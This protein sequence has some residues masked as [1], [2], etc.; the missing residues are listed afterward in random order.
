M[1]T[2]NVAVLST[3]APLI[4]ADAER[5]TRLS[6]GGVIGGLL[7]AAAVWIGLTVLGLAVNLS[8]IE[9]SD[10]AA[11]LKG[12]G[13]AAGIWSLVVWVVALFAGA[14]VASHTAGIIE[15]PHGALHGIVLWSL[16]TVLGIVV[17][18]GTLGT[19]VRGAVATAEST[20]A[21]ANA[22]SSGPG[23]LLGLDVD[24]LIQPLN[25][26]LRSEGKPAVTASQV[27]GA[28]RDV[29]VNA[30]QQGH[31]DRDV[32]IRAL[33]EKASLAHADAEDL[34]NQIDTWFD[35]HAEIARDVRGAVLSAA[36]STGAALW[37]VFFALALGL[38]ASLIGSTMG[39]GRRQRRAA[40]LVTER[41]PLATTRE[42]HP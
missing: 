34:A 37:W 42:A 14:A 9:P 26:R 38:G 7:V 20:V 5:T 17:V 4:P 10:P 25:D 23:Q 24:A 18:V 35:A 15:R 21:A 11:S 41:P 12:I 2:D 29:T 28:L 3:V 32:V 27:E 39:I 6:W 16:A 31:L 30:V 8:A 33:T 13:V 1:T 19:V 36:T 22:A 40:A